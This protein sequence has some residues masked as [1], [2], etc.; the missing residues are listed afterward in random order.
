MKKK[1]LEESFIGSAKLLFKIGWHK[2]IG[3]YVSINNCQHLKSQNWDEWAF[4][5]EYE[6]STIYASSS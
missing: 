6:A 2:S 3:M 4:S 1:G 5:K